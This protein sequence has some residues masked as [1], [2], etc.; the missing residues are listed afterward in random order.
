[1]SNGC[2]FVYTLPEYVLDRIVIINGSH[3][4]RVSGFKLA[5]ASD[6]F[7][8]QLIELRRGELEKSRVRE[9]EDE[10]QKHSRRARARS[11]CDL[12]IEPLHVSYDDLSGFEIML[13][14]TH[15]SDE[16][17]K[18]L[19]NT[20]DSQKLVSVLKAGSHFEVPDLVEYFIDAMKQKLSTH[21]VW[22]YWTALEPISEIAPIVANH[23][24]NFL[25]NHF[26]DTCA[27]DDFILQPFE[28]LEPLLRDDALNT[29]NELD[30]FRQLERWVTAD[31]SKRCCH[32]NELLGCLRLGRLNLDEFNQL[33][34]SNL[35]SEYLDCCRK[36]LTI[37]QSI[38]ESNG[39]G[40]NST[41][42]QSG[43]DAE[44]QA[45]LKRPRLPHAAIFV[46][47]GW[48]GNQDDPNFG[49][50]RAIQVY[51]SRSN[52]WRRINND[53]IAL[54]EGHA[55]SGCVLYKNKIYVIG[56]Y[57]AS[58]PTQMLKVLE[59]ATGTWKH[60][61]PMHE[62][63]NYICA[64]LLDNAIY[65]LGGHNGRHRLNTVERYDPEQNNWTFVSQMRQVRS[66]AGADSLNGK[67]YVCGG[68][69]GHHFYDSVECYDPK[70]DQWT[71]L[72]PMQNIRSGVSVTGFNNCLYAIGGNDGLQ[73]LRTVERYDPETN[74]WQTMP[75]M[76]RQ[77][78]NFCIV[79]MDDSIYVMGGWS[80]ETNSTI[81]LVEKWVPGMHSSWEQVKELHLPASANCCCG[82][83]GLDVIKDFL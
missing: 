30:L 81:A 56:G 43:D 75:S 68:F 82:I 80:D 29:S 20:L 13:S 16:A 21:N 19:T 69:D 31:P 52:T 39:A 55:Y 66:D 3:E 64:C 28:R 42:H 27:C 61:S 37:A 58:G 10:K 78:S 71:L 24:R 26:L 40:S 63:R 6:Y 25:L 53:G 45:Y 60:L 59:L 36:V 50:S 34:A 1:M 44:M 22:T 79:S 11:L 17:R 18:D 54:D 32:I 72:A 73:R 51:N 67:I 38:I 23:C 9:E 74:Q 47:G 57:I 48:E 65:A 14:F 77:R 41:A 62:K 12:Q 2:N 7:K 76:I 70:V 49:P 33:K 35:M 83:K 5:K 8:R 4:H 46:V 15:C